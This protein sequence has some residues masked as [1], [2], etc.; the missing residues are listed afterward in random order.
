MRSTG[1]KTPVSVAEAAAA[2]IAAREVAIAA[3]APPAPE[4]PAF[5]LTNKRGQ[6]SRN[7]APPPEEFRLPSYA[8]CQPV[9]TVVAA[10]GVR[11]PAAGHGLEAITRPLVAL[12]AQVVRRQRAVQSSTMWRETE[13]RQKAR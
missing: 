2:A 7:V 4:P 5:P 13:A 12:G 1:R 11:Q 6:R 8:N 9:Q 10:G 3:A